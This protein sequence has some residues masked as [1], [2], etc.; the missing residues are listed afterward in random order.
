MV[1]LGFLNMPLLAALEEGLLDRYARGPSPF[2]A[3]VTAAVVEEIARVTLVALAWAASRR[4]FNDPL[5]GLVYGCMVGLGMALWESLVRVEG[6][7]RG[8]SLPP[9]EVVRVFGH[10]V[11]GG[12]AAFPLGPH[13]VRHPGAILWWMP[14]LGGAMLLH[15]IVDYVSLSAREP[16]RPGPMA[17]AL[18]SVAMLFG[19]AGFGALVTRGSEWSKAMFSKGK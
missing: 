15:F 1:A 16:G 5:D 12:I 10:M 6:L 14:C 4:K 9:A 17:S 8:A 3:A 18:V 2:E 13:R 19:I 11:L 7:E